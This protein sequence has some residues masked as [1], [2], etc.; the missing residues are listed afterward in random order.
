M[1]AKKIENGM[2]IIY[3]RELKKMFD[4]KFREGYRV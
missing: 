1:A 4:S 2:K 3:S